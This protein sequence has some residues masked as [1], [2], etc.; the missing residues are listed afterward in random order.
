MKKIVFV[1]AVLIPILSKAQFV[2]G[3]K[4]LGG[5]VQLNT[6]DQ[7]VKDGPAHQYRN[8]S[9]LSNLGIFV[10]D[11]LELGGILG[12][13]SFYQ[14]ID[15]SS[16]SIEYTSKSKS[17]TTGLYAQQYLT[18]TDKFLFAFLIQSHFSRG[19]SISPQ[20]DPS[21]GSYVDSKTLNY[22]INSSLHPTFLFFPSP[23]WGFEFSIASLNHIYY[24][25]L[26]IDTRYNQFTLSYGGV[27]LGVS[28][29]FRKLKD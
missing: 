12:F 18:L 13:N 22:S 3:D 15:G 9:L 23:Q 7:T 6:Q 11:K 19:N 5:S 28:Y 24:R 29:Y 2:K 4:V 25:N 10:N 20:Y 27:N 14:N 16:T 26:S 17:L 1:I 8:F 21:S